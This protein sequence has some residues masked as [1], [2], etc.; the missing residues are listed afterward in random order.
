VNASSL[1]TW[2][3]KNSEIKKSI[4]QASRKISKNV[5]EM[6]ELHEGV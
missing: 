6:V 4:T 5:A 2:K 1:L 3:R